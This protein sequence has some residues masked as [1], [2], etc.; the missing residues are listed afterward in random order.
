VSFD[1]DGGSSFVSVI[2]N[3]GE[4]GGGEIECEEC[5][6]AEE[7]G[8]S[9]DSVSSVAPLLLSGV[10]VKVEVRRTGLVPGDGV[11]NSGSCW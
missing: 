3:G 5:G 9:A 11:R 10:V 1:D 8:E 4:S 6:D 2:V 7:M